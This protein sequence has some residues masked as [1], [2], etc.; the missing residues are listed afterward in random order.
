[1]HCSINAVSAIQSDN[2]NIWFVVSS[3][4]VSDYLTVIYATYRKFAGS[5]PD[6]GIGIFH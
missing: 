4:L 1:V 5:I 3:Q 2:E 6:G